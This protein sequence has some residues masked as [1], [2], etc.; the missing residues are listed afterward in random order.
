MLRHSIRKGNSRVV[1]AAPC[2]FGKTRV[3]LEILKNTAS[4]GKKG[5]FICDR[6]KLVQQ[7]LDEFDRAGI[8]CGVMQGDHWR[9]DPNADIQIA[10]IQTLAKRRYQPIFHV[11]VID[12]C[13]THYKHVTEL[14]DKNSKVI[15]IG[16]SATPYSKGLGKHY[17]DLVVPITTEQL[18]DQEYLC[19]VKYYGG[20]HVNLKGV[21]T[22]RLATGGSDYDPKSLAKA[23]ED[24]QKLVGDIIENFKRFGKG[25]TI[26]FSPSI[27]TS[28][29]LVEMFRAA[30][31]SAEH[32]DGYMDEEERRIIYDSHD[33][34]D[35]QVL[36]CS[37]LLNTGYD[38]PKVETLIDLKPTKS[39]I[40]YI[41]RA[42]RIM[43]LHPNKTHAVYLDHA[44]NVAWHGFPE[45]IVPESLDTG[46]KTYNERELV[47]DKKEAE[48]SVCPQ[49]Y[50]HYVV[51]CACGYERPPR[52]TFKTD[53]QILQELKRA[54]RIASPEDK[55]R[56]LGEFQAYAKKKGYKPGWASF[57]YRSK[58]G[59][60]PNKITPERSEGIS[61][62]TLDYVKHLHIKR[63]KSA[64]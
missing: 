22:R 28:K 7:A 6:I 3:A 13:H 8:T 37:Q 50:Q 35:F 29:K 52:E 61:Q 60:W 24:D 2:S 43:R 1:L 15:F 34:G 46:D 54:N 45:S 21:K 12:E 55:S 17:Q 51:K 36:S 53:K 4:N 47:K 59:V 63:V 42:G 10:S 32:I 31:I 40:S 25:Q 11:A 56:W 30:G 5:I 26:A 38:A 39:L 18:L 16:L 62:E 58:F 57:A 49:C 20:S 27:K 33:E 48:L 19:P 44:G 23:T 14:M 41:Q 9:T 64:I